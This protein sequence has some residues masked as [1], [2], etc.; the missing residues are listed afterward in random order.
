MGLILCFC[1]KHSKFL[2]MAIQEQ[3]LFLKAMYSY[4]LGVFKAS[5]TVKHTSIISTSTVLPQRRPLLL[6]IKFGVGDRCGGDGGQMVEDAQ[7][8]Q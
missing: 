3:G 8:P 1:A 2:S 4:K 6:L 5:K 7:G